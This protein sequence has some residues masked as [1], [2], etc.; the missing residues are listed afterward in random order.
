M[1]GGTAAQGKPFGCRVWGNLHFSG[2]GGEEPLCIDQGAFR[3]AFHL[4]MLA[5]VLLNSPDFSPDQ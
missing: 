1:K 5:K 2:E 4:F 3:E